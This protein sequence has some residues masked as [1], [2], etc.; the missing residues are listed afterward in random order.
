MNI[1]VVPYYMIRTPQF[2]VASGTVTT[3]FKAEQIVTDATAKAI[4]RVTLILNKTQFVSG[5]GNEHVQEVDILGSAITDPSNI[6]IS[7]AIPTLVP[8]Q[9]YIFARIGLKVAGLEKWIFSS[10]QKL[11]F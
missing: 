3:S 10:V 1:E 4:E 11:S 7:A 2:S 6:S 8:T 5:D 9:N